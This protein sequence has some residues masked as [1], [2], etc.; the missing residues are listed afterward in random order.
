MKPELHVPID[1]AQPV[2]VDNYDVPLARE[3]L[4]IQLHLEP[5]QPDDA[6][7]LAKALELV[8]DWIGGELRW[9]LGTML[10][11]GVPYESDH[12][13]YVENY[14]ELLELPPRE[15]GST[16]EEWGDAL[17]LLAGP[18][19]AYGVVC[20]SSPEPKYAP[21]TSFRFYADVDRV[22]WNVAHVP[23]L[24]VLRVTV[25]TDQSLGLFMER[26]CAL[27]SMLRVR[28]GSAGLM[29]SGSAIDGYWSEWKKIAHAY[30]LRHV[31]VDLGE[32]V[33]L[34]RP[35]H[36]RIRTV[37][38]LTFLGSGIRAQLDKVQPLPAI[39]PNG[40]TIQKMGDVTLI[41]AGDRPFRGD[42][43]R[44]D[45]P[46]SYVRADQLV[47]PLRAAAGIRFFDVW[48]FN[49]TRKWLTRFE[50]IV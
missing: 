3:V 29:L 31:G 35:F 19:S 18:V 11:G 39:V 49:E 27:A 28:W 5:M 17:A 10:G 32:Y 16:D 13:D 1:P 40:V 38:W 7:R 4:G 50:R 36:D 46:P 9:T 44:L 21:A 25:P 8:K 22:D 2:A 48:D 45:V 43:N 14:P 42:L 30:C 26:A 15:A 34:L 20:G 41:K 6:G 37:N 23:A 33:A 24:S 12:F 47:R